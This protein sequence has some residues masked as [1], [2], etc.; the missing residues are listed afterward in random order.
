MT[1]DASHV[2]DTT[3]DTVTD[4]STMTLQQAFEAVN[5]IKTNISQVLVGQDLVIENVLT[6]LFAG[7]HV[8]LEGVPGLGKT[9]LVRALA[10]SVQV[11][12][13]RVQFTPDLMPSDVLG[14]SLYDMKA[15]QFTTKR[16]PA[17][18]NILLAD[19]I[20]R[21]PAKTQSALLEVMQEQQITIDGTSTALASP[22]MVLAT[23][24]P[25]DQEG[26]YPLP[27]AELDRF[28]MK[29]ELQY[30]DEAAEIA[31]LKLN[32]EI[33]SN[34]QN[35]ETLASVINADKIA[36]IKNLATA[37]IVDEKIFQYAV[38][39]A[40]QTRT[41]HGVLHGAGVRASIN[42]LK[43]AKVNA[44]MNGRDFVTPDDVKIVA[45]NILRHR[46]VLSAELELEGV[47]QAQVITE[48]LAS[49]EAPRI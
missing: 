40:R 10:Q 27:E 8:L 21:A 36:Q 32:T 46:L 17:F 37:T 23:Q 30:P 19:E 31:L 48:I 35:V 1:T 29:I 18:T 44:L 4:P 34:E 49:I 12:F 9:L 3:A 7:G 24:N 13:A 11:D 47:S 42:L 28:M 20:N 38:D 15:G 14:H 16:G 39:I 2:A 26:T 25:L 41:W 43:A 6:T 5:H 22:F 33:K 45:P